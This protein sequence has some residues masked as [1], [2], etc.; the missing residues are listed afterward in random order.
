MPLGGLTLKWKSAVSAGELLGVAVFPDTVELAGGEAAL[1]ASIELADQGT[2]PRYLF[3]SER[4]A[5]LELNRPS[6]RLSIE[7]Q[8][9]D[10]EARLAL[11]AGG[12]AA[13]PGARLVVPLD[14]ADTFVKQSVPTNALDLK[15]NPEIIWSSRTGLTFNG[16]PTLDVD[17]PISTSFAGIRIHDLHMALRRSGQST[18]ERPVLELEASTG[19]DVQLGPVL[20]TID[21]LGLRIGVD[22]AA[23]SKNVGFADLA[24]GFKPPSGIGI[25]VDAPA[26]SGGG[27]LFF[28]PDKG[29]YGGIVQLTIKGSLTL[30]AIGLVTTR[31]PDGTDGFSFL[32]MITAEG[33]QPIQLGL[34]FTLTGIGG[35]LAVNRTCDDEFLRAGLKTKVLDAVL[36]PADPIKNAA[37]IL[38]TFD[39]AFPSRRGSYL[40]GP[41][42]QIS[43]GHAAGADD[44]P[45]RRARA[46]QPHAPHRP[47]TAGRRDA[48]RAARPAAPAMSAIGV[49]DFDQ[50]SISLD[51][52]LYDSRLAGKFPMTGSMAMRVSWGARAGVRAVDRRVP[53]GVQAAAVPPRARAAGDHVQQQQRL[54]P[55][56]RAVL[57]DHRQHAADRREGRAVSPARGVRHHRTARLRRPHPVR[58]VRVRRRLLRLGAADVQLEEP[59]QGVRRGRAVGPAPLH[60]R[61]KATFEIFWCDVSV[62]FDKTLIAGERPAACR[63]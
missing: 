31:L 22:F 1:D 10:P 12:D 43:L 48:E 2:T 11:R 33:F 3:G 18:E 17:L 36:F 53:P 28:D 8:A 59:L 27:Y 6:L 47:R 26:V 46:R 16:A 9:S 51:A 13:T 60:V 50:G 41:A 56:R 57:R 62:R 30:T 44:E 5:R 4:T 39:R 45:R 42:V 52:V 25:A 23:P 20:A 24:F 37:H 35:L 54:P 40:F 38:S 14:D 19:L 49:I 21:R 61:G 29:Q 7:G 55:A 32:I 63:R 15:F 58:P 34:G